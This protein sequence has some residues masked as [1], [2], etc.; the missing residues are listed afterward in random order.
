MPLPH[1]HLVKDAPIRL[2]FKY[3]LVASAMN[4][5]DRVAIMVRLESPARSDRPYVTYRLAADGGCSL[6]HYDLTE[7]E[8]RHDMLA[9][10]GLVPDTGGR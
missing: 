4:R 7:E 3:E 8:A 6:G 9:R 10:I 1:E 5:H 2:P